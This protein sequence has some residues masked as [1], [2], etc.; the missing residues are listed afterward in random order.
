VE[1]RS[2]IWGAAIVL[3]GAMSLIAAGAAQ[4]RQSSLR[5]TGTFAGGVVVYNASGTLLDDQ[6]VT[7]TVKS[8]K[9]G[10]GQVCERRQRVYPS[11]QADKGRSFRCGVH[12]R[13]AVNER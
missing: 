12:L 3:L 10:V 13:R 4:S 11:T 7:L 9:R 8:L 5:L 6:R 1:N 2:A